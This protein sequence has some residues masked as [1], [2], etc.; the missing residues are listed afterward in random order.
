M[1]CREVEHNEWGMRMFSRR[2]RMDILEKVTSGGASHPRA[3]G[4]DEAGHGDTW[5]I[6]L[7]R[8]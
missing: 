5:H 7:E 8:L 6:A 2:T 4:K 3:A 1:Q